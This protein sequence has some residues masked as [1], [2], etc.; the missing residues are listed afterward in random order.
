M[1]GFLVLTM[2]HDIPV[3]SAFQPKIGIPFDE[4]QP[5]SL[6]LSPHLNHFWWS[7]GSKRPNGRSLGFI[8][9]VSL[10]QVS[11]GLVPLSLKKYLSDN[12]NHE[13][14]QIIIQTIANLWNMKIIK[15]AVFFIILSIIIRNKIVQRCPLT[16][17][18]R[19]TTLINFAICVIRK[20]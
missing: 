15:K 16:L 8:R 3:W 4:V 18:P 11:V 7:D 5:P 19:S 2:L 17:N 20:N 6:G 9:S 12:K 14:F 13:R 1:N 10:K